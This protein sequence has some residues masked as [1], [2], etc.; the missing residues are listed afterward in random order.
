MA[1]ISASRVGFMIAEVM[2][3]AIAIGRKAALMPWR[4]G[5][6]KEMLEAPQVVLTPSSSRSRRTRAKTWRPAV[7]MAPIGMT[8]GS[9]TM[10][11]AG[12]PKSAARSTI[13]FATAKRTSGSSEMP[14]S[15]LE[16]ATTGTLYFFTSGRTRSSRS[17]SPVTEFS[18]RAAVR[19]LE[20][21]LERAGDRAVDRK[22]NV[23]E[24]LHELDHLPHQ[25]RL[26]LVRVRVRVVDDAGVDIEHG[27]A[28]GDLLERV[29][30]D[31]GEAAGLELGGEDLAARR[32]DALANH[33]E[34]LVEADDDGLRARIRR[35]CGS[36]DAG[37]ELGRDAPRGRGR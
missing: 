37:L 26:G 27:G 33:A 32:V 36:C 8:S 7:A 6:P 18:E 24:G 12:M 21:G 15:S 20:A 13:F 1:C 31:G 14:V 23:D 19:G 11:W 9:T 2:P 17:S 30:L 16:M 3:E 25:R 22:R 34:R 10:S 5:R 29:L 28:A 4:F 35:W